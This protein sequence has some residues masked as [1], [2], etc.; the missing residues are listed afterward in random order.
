MGIKKELKQ[1][2]CRGCDGEFTPWRSTQVACS[3]PC[4]IVVAKAK[5]VKE[6]DREKR[7]AEKDRRE[8][9]RCDREKLLTKSDY[10]R[11]AQKAFNAYI[12]FRDR[13]LP[14]ICC[15]RFHK[16]QWHAGHYLSVGANPELRFNEDNCHKQASYCNNHKSGNQSEYRMNLIAKIGA[17]AVDKLEGPHLPSK[18]TISDIKRIQAC[19]TDKLKKAKSEL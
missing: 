5:R 8:G 18:L 16:G 6:E 19:Y 17:E 9:I 12:R 14:C 10:L 11:R 13:D 4:S 15:N 3:L 7:T 2:R 1:K